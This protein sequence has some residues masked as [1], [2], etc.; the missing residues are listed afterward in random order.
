MQGG[1]PASPR[2]A[3]F[4]YSSLIRRTLGGLFRIA[5]PTA[6]VAVAVA[7]VERWWPAGEKRGRLLRPLQEMSVLRG[8]CPLACVLQRDRDHPQGASPGPHFSFLFLF[9][10]GWAPLPHMGKN[11]PL[12]CRVTAY[13]GTGTSGGG[14]CTAEGVV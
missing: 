12:G 13:L 5:V 9:F 14:L 1:L 8:E 10:C 3:V 6:V 7:S 11:E 4:N 2:P